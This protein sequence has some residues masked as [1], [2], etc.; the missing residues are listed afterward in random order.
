MDDMLKAL[1][2]CL[3]KKLDPI[4]DQLDK[5]EKNAIQ[6]H[7]D[8]YDDPAYKDYTHDLQDYPGIPA[9]K[10]RTRLTEEDIQMLPLDNP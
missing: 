6:E 9:T 3:D 1:M 8:W 5:L 2:S 4:V 10:A 7:I